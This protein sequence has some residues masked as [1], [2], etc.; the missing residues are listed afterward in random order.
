ME[1]ARGRWFLT[2]YARRNRSCDTRAVLKAVERLES[3]MSSRQDVAELE[4]FR[5]A[6]IDMSSAITRAKE[7]IGAGDPDSEHERNRLGEASVELDSI[8]RETEKA[9]SEILLAAEAVQEVAWTLR[10]QGVDSQV[11]D[12]LDLNATNVYTACSFQDLTGQRTAKVIQALRYVE[13]RLNAVIDLLG[14]DPKRAIAETVE[15]AALRTGQHDEASTAPN[16]GAQ[17]A[18]TEEGYAG[19]VVT[20]EHEETDAAGGTEA[21]TTHLED[22][23]PDGDLPAE[24]VS[25]VEF[26]EVDE[27]LA[28]DD[29]LH[30]DIDFEIDDN[31]EDVQ[32]GTDTVP[33]TDISEIDEDVLSATEDGPLSHPDDGSDDEV[34]SGVSVSPEDEPDESGEPVSDRLDAMP[35]GQRLALFS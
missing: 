5:R 12:R 29:D 11:C 26:V 8:V 6:V 4:A 19:S 9:T 34:G 32:S 15:G 25:V 22:D 2:E 1:T 27:V 20:L 13:G 17:T 28:I 33:V 31:E 10:E 3:A 16:I 35:I 14:V 21:T 18:E 23:D 30:E 7:E 24:T